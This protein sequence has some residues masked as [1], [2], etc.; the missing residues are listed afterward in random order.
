MNFPAL[1]DH[2]VVFAWF[3][4]NLLVLGFAAE[5]YQSTGKRSLLL[6]AVSAG[7]GAALMLLPWIAREARPSWS[8]WSF[9]KLATLA[10]L[11]FWVAGIRLLVRDYV[12]LLA[13]GAHDA[14]GSELATD[15]KA[16]R[17]DMLPPDS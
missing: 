5:A 13:R 6:I 3:L 14:L 17:A 2:F 15:R 1:L 8:L 10:D 12:S 9:H 11:A 16:A 4:A 7:L